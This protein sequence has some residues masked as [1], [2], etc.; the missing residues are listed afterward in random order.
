VTLIS[1]EPMDGVKSE[2]STFG[3]ENCWG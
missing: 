2:D 3:T 1:D